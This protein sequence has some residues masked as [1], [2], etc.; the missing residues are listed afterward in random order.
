MNTDKLKEKVIKRYINGESPKEIYQSLGKVK[1]WFFKWLKRYKLDGQDWIK[2]HSRRPHQ[3][4]KRIDQ[5]KK[6]MVIATRKK[7]ENKLYAQIG[8]L[9]INYEL[10]NRGIAPL[11]ISSINKILSR[12]HLT[13]QKKRYVPKGVDCPSPEVTRSNDLHQ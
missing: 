1:N 2:E 12:S 8:A 10:K 3:S 13:H 6:Q 9:A 5:E 4:P 7:L 11:P